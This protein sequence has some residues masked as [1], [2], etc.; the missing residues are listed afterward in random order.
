MPVKQMAITADQRSGRA[1]RGKNGARRG[2][3]E[4]ELCEKS[5]L[6]CAMDGGEMRFVQG[7]TRSRRS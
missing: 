4:L 7:P 3:A 6:Y 1:R 5:Q 2:A